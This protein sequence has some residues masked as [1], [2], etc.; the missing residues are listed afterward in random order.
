MQYFGYPVKTKEKKDT[1]KNR[2][3]HA[4]L[5]KDGAI[6]F[7][8]SLTQVT[9][10]HKSR[11]G[12]SIVLSRELEVGTGPTPHPTRA[13]P[14]AVVSPFLPKVRQRNARA[15]VAV[16]S[17]HRYPPRSWHPGLVWFGE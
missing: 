17:A 14:C 10:P 3:A 13:R 8:T 4:S 15:R 9:S 1:E 12:L 2:Q 5:P 7:S 16:A 11:L 6:N